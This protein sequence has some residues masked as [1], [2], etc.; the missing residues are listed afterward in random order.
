MKNGP[1]HSGGFVVPRKKCLYCYHCC[2]VS[3]VNVRGVAASADPTPLGHCDA[4]IERESFPV[5]HEQKNRGL[6][7]DLDVVTFVLV[8]VIIHQ[9]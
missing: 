6:Q 9:F 7:T 4:K 3:P 5:Q 8:N 2:W 1:P